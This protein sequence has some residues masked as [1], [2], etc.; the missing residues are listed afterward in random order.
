MKRFALYVALALAVALPGVVIRL[1]GIAIPAPLAV[2]VYG[3]AVGSA[4]FLLSWGAEGETHLSQGLIIAV[5]AIVTVLP[6][7]S[8]DIYLA[9]QAG[10]NPDSPYAQY[11][12]ANMT[13]ANRLLVGTI[14]LL[15]ILLFW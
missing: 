7:Y 15:L 14:W 2:L 12:A 5:L 3:V 4:G 1:A 11:A 13:G 9:Y 10:V 8:L 6:E